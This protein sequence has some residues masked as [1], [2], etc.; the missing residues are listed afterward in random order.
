MTLPPAV[1]IW[2]LRAAILLAGA[3]AGGIAQRYLGTP[4]VEVR[5][6]VKDVVR[7][8]IHEVVKVEVHEV[9]AKAKTLVVYRDRTVSPAGEIHE[10]SVECSG[11]TSLATSHTQAASQLDV[12]HEATHEAITLSTPVR[13][14]WRVAVLAGASL[15]APLLPLAGPLVLGAEVDYRLAGPLS[16][17]LWAS[18]S[19]A[20][21]LSLAVEF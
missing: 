6:E 17:G 5:T 21:G 11:E 13:P 1:S 14:S 16:A 15:R 4:Q 9:E 18:T 19:G 12:K 10:R 8:V 20:A 7:D 3:L 2:G